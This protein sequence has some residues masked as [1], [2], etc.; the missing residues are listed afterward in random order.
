MTVRVH[1]IGLALLNL[2]EIVDVS[3]KYFGKEI[4]VVPTWGAAIGVGLARAHPNASS[5]VASDFQ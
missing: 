1:W 4:A 2:H 5:R 3:H